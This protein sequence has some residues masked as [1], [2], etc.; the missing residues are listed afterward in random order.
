MRRRTRPAPIQE[1][2]TTGRHF[3]ELIRR[4]NWPPGFVS[5]IDTSDQRDR[6]RSALSSAQREVNARTGRGW[7]NG[8]MDLPGTTWRA[9]PGRMERPGT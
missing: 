5:Q 9:P 8:T 3:T 1:H 6:E 7:A 2:M 4:H